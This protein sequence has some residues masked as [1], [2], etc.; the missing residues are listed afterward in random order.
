MRGSVG[1]RGVFYWGVLN[2]V[3]L[4]DV[5]WWEISLDVQAKME[6]DMKMNTQMKDR[7]I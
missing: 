6:M 2:G 3:M 7:N 5:V 1:L 4:D